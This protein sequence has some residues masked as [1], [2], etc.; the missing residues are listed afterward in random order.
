MLP[1]FL[2]RWF[3]R[4]AGCAA[5]R[6]ATA[7]Q[8]E[9]S[10]TA[11]GLVLRVKGEAR[12]ECVGVLLAGLLVPAAR[13]PAV[14]ALDLSEL[15]SLS[16]QAPA[17]L[18]AYRRSAARTGG[19]VRLVG[20]LQPAVKESLLRARLFDLVGTGADADVPWRPGPFAETAQG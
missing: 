5:P 15:R 13:R 6:P 11:D 8:V 20:V 12:P 2:T 17:V 18:A 19:V 14:V 9:V 10:Q 4:A 7:L 3:A 16:R 1:S